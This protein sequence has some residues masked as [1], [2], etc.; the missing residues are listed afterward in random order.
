MSFHH[1]I[2]VILEADASAGWAFD[3][4]ELFPSNLSV[5]GIVNKHD[6]FAGCLCCASENGPNRVIQCP[7]RS[8]ILFGQ[9]LN[10]SLVEIKCAQDRL[11]IIG[12][13]S[14]ILVVSLPPNT[15]REREVVS[16]AAIVHSASYCVIELV[17][18][19]GFHGGLRELSCK[20]RDV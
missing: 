6:G 18:A 4:P 16:S 2:D 11:E 17:C 20:G 14:G 3:S 7:A 15:Q 8:P 19:D 12:V 1:S 5:P 13:C 10:F 9:D